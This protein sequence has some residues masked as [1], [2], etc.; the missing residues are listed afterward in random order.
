M[1]KAIGAK[2]RLLLAV[3]VGEAMVMTLSATLTGICAGVLLAY[4][5]RLSEGFRQELPTHFAL[6][7]IVVPAMLVLMILSSFF[8]A[9]IATHSLRR[10]RAIDILRSV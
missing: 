2:G 10:R 3:F 7:P 5:F 4:T 1:L 8:S 6:D 9:V